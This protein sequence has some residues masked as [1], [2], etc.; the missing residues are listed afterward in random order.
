MRKSIFLVLIVAGLILSACASLTPP[1]VEQPA[2]NPD[3]TATSAPEVESNLQTPL[4]DPTG[5][6]ISTAPECRLA[7]SSKSN[8]EMEALMPK[9]GPEWSI[10]AQDAY[11]TIT[12]YSDFQCPYCV[13]V[14][15]ILKQLVAK[16]PQD[17]RLVYRHFPLSSI[18]DKAELSAQAAEAAGIQGKF[19]DMHDLLF[20]RQ[21]QWSQLTVEQF[22]EWL[23]ALA[24]ELNL[25]VDQFTQ[26]LNSQ[27]LVD[28]A[29]NAW[30]QGG[31]AG[32]PG[33][34]F[35]FFNG[36]PYQGQSDLDTLS[37]I[38]DSILLEERHFAECPP[39]T[40]SQDKTYQAT[41]K[42]E[43]GEIIVELFPAQAPLA[44]NSFIF[45]ASQGWYDGVTFH[46][47]IP[48]AVAQAGD[49]SGSGFGG[50]GYEFDN[51]IT[52][53]LKFDQP[54]IL[55]MANAGPGTNGS[56]FFITL[57]PMSQ[58]DGNYTIFGK[59]IS[60]MDIVQ[61]LTPR[62]PQQGGSLPPGDKILSITIR[63]Q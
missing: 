28:L 12:E 31:A 45:L 15:P 8:Q 2:A 35:L 27:E 63:E 36:L 16:Y 56:Q 32:L 4:A 18:H 23:L 55:G 62:D 60:G 3:Q 21:D 13:Q 6:A 30:E 47:V 5:G 39:M 42:T 9:V 11:L 24:E 50:P 61:A 58:L 48:S 26:D 25:D 59:V 44:V 41:I 46:R 53:N 14:A 33:T 22:Q 29:K 20:A 57:A 7:T 40:V 38:V 52:T 51:E 17:V 34:P 19:W 43:K 37:A 10:G 54:G 1:P 49:P